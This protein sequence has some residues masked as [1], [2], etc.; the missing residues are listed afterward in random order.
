ML[1]MHLKMKRGEGLD[2]FAKNRN[3]LETEDLQ[4][5]EIK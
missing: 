3:S 4:M 2:A 5:E 1:K